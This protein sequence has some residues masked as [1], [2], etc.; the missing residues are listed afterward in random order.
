[1]R[2]QRTKW[3]F[4]CVASY[5]DSYALFLTVTSRKK[6]LRRSESANLA[7]FVWFNVLFWRVIWNYCYR[8]SI[9]RRFF[10]TPIT[11]H[12]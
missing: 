11:L 5:R 4:T 9:F 12:S 8:I 7:Y 3:W 10:F 2:F 1:L 6:L